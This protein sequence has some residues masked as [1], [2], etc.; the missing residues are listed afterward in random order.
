MS[1]LRDLINMDKDPTKILTDT[2]GN[3]TLKNIENKKTLV[4]ETP[5]GVS[6]S[7]MSSFMW[8][9]HYNKTLKF[10]KEGCYIGCL[11]G[12][13]VYTILEQLKCDPNKLKRK[14]ESIKYLEQ[15]TGNTAYRKHNSFGKWHLSDEGFS[16]FNNPFGISLGYTNSENNY[17][18]WY[19]NNE[20]EPRERQTVNQIE[21]Q[22]KEFNLI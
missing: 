1:F 9:Y 19:I 21:K 18:I 2:F 10:I 15:L 5:Y 7:K 17:E 20:K 13:D 12:G 14:P 11:S 16:M 8:V 4:W 3:P 6:F 22:L